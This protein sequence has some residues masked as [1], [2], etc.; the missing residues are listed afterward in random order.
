[1]ALITKS[2]KKI[3]PGEKALLT[4]PS[5]LHLMNLTD[6]NSYNKWPTVHSDGLEIIFR[7]P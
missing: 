6:S 1:M 4:G 7:S 5:E 2:F 3:K